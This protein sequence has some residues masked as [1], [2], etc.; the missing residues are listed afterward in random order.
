M[1]SYHNIHAAR[2]YRL[3]VFAFGWAPVP[4]N[5]KAPRPGRFLRTD[6]AANP[7]DVGKQLLHS[8]KHLALE[9]VHL[10]H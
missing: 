3:R 8:R 6:M 7:G 5:E 4:L 1:A 10:R 9:F 2:Q